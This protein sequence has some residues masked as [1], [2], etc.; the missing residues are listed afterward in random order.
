MRNNP[1]VAASVQAGAFTAEEHFEQ[2]GRFEGRNP[3]AFVDLDFYLQQNPDVAEAV[4]N[5]STTAYDHFVTYGAQEQRQPSPLFD[6]AFYLEQNPDVDSAVTAGTLTPFAHFFDYG[7][8]N[9]ELRAPAPGIDLQAYAQANP[10]VLAQAEAGQ[11]GIAEHLFTY[12]FAEGRDLGNGLSLADF[13]NDPDFQAAVASGNAAAALA[14][15]NEVAPFLPEFTPPEGWTPAADTSIPVDFIPT[16]GV[17]LQVPQGIEIPDDIELPDTFEQ[18]GSPETPDESG[19]GGGSPST[20]TFSVTENGTSPNISLTFAGSATGDITVT[21]NAGALT[22]TRDGHEASTKPDLTDLDAAGIPGPLT[23]SAATFAVTGLAA[24]LAAGAT[25][26][27]ASGATTVQLTA[28][29]DNAAKLVAD[30]LSNLTLTDTQSAAAIGN[31]LGKATDAHV[32]ATSMDGTDLKAVADNIAKVATDGITGT[33]ALSTTGLDET[34]IGNLLGAK[35]AAAAT[36]NVDATSMTDPEL[37][38][39]N[40]GIAKVDAIT[41]LTLTDT[42]SAAAIGNLLG[43]ATDAHVT[44]TSMD[45]T[46]L[47]AVADNIA[48]VATDGITGTLALSTTGLDETDIGN[49][50]GAKTAAAAT[51]NVDAT[52][53]TDPELGAVNTGIAKVDAITNL[54]LTDTQSAAAIG[55]LLGKATDAHVTATSMDGTDLKAVADNIAK[56]ATDG[57]TGTLALSTTGLDETDIGNLLGAKTATTA[58]VNVDTAS[59]TGMDAAEL[60]AVAQGL[61]K[62]DALTIDTTHQMQGQAADISGRSFSLT[63][64]DTTT[65]YLQLATTSGD[66]TITL[67]NVTT[68]NASVIVHAS[69]GTDTIA[70]GTGTFSVLFD[71][72]ADGTGGN[73]ITGFDVGDGGDVLAFDDNANLDLNGADTETFDS[74]DISIADQVTGNVIV[75]TNTITGIADIETMLANQS[76]VTGGAVVVAYNTSTTQTELYY[77]SNGANDGSGTEVTLLGVVDITQADVASLTAYNFHVI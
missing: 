11:I 17:R 42:Q 30:G 34:D 74:G 58:T 29:S 8:G 6:P 47:K 25:K 7:Q 28:L 16:E 54:T 27:D 24:K 9:G 70:F 1:D 55:N 35:T 40:T 60:T 75:A 62:I 56:V 64:T 43:K 67:T 5:G 61:A 19:S 39:V 57:I 21:E 69:T 26:V 53:M 31:L 13:A 44:A 45:G 46:D 12:G 32:T 72:T 48:K 77:D 65:D 59:D 36:V 41:N 73:S 18:P 4:A 22:F 66:D 50:L 33:L 68:T 20:P 37:G 49:L 52:S 51:V 3:N 10:D 38:A 2:Y 14:R 23:M 63:G 71:H 15:V 76:G